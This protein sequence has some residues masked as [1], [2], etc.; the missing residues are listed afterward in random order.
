MIQSLLKSV[1]LEEKENDYS[2]AEIMIST[3]TG[4]P[5]MYIGIIIACMLILGGGVY[6]INKKVINGKKSI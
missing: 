1:G 5:A 4:S 2:T 6:M 3:A